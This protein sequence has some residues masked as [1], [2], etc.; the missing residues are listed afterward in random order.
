MRLIDEAFQNDL[1]SQ[2]STKDCF[3]IGVSGGRDSMVLLHLLHSLGF[4]DLIVCHV[5]HQLRGTESEKDEL[6]VAKKAEEFGYPFFSHQE[7]VRLTAKETRLSLETAARNVRHQFFFK[8]AREKNCPRL[9][10]AHHADDQV[11]TVIMNFFRGAGMK[12]IGG[13]R[14]ESVLESCDGFSLNVLRPLLEIPRL[15]IDEYVGKLKIAYREDETNTELFALRN[16]L[17]HR[18]IPEISEVFGRDVQGSVLRLSEI[19]RLD[20][21]DAE[22]ETENLYR[23]ILVEES[24]ASLAVPMLR[25]LSESKRRRLILHWLR[26]CRVGDCGYEEAR[27]ISEMT[28]SDS[29]PAKVNLPGNCFVRRRA[30]LLFLEGQS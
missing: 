5:N 24:G 16:R 15:E 1:C 6:F 26:Q 20:S 14:R 2:L 4:R 22:E 29:N 11:E 28:L 12:G 10:L 9:L 17:R 13:M 8:I 23:A 3:L 27:R 19:A 18:L 7:D 25:A 21:N 30:G